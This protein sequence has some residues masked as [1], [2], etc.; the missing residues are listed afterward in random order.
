[1]YAPFLNID[2]LTP[3]AIAEQASSSAF[4]DLIVLEVNT[5]P[6]GYSSAPRY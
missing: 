4:F 5:I 1:M 6:F 2:V 3:H